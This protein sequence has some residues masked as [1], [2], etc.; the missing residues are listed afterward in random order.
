[1]AIMKCVKKVLKYLPDEHYIRLQYLCRLRKPLRL[2]NPQTFNEKLQWLKL[3]DR[4]PLYTRMVDK[5]EAKR[6]VTQ[7]IGEGYTAV[8]YGVWNRPEEIDFSALPS[9]FV[10]KTTHD[11]GGAYICRD[12]SRLIQGEALTPDGEA[13]LRMLD[14]HLQEDY[15]F[16]SREWPYHN[17][18]RR[19][20]AEEYLENPGQG[21]LLVYKVFCFG[22][23]PE[24][25]QVIQDDKTDRETIDYFDCEWNL[26]E[27]RQDFPNSAS[28]LPKPERL[29]EMLSLSSKLA[30]TRPFIRIDW[31]MVD[32]R[33]LFSEFTL[34]SDAG[35]A[36]FT[37]EIWD[38]KLGEKIQ[39]PA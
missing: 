2:R 15:Y 28:H 20:L 12:K 6:I 16:Q 3:Y 14:I 29:E 10:L 8:N 27:L 37:P 19:I 26:L 39:L 22:G 9:R 36:P 23:I 18:P 34:Y 11:C 30:G 4:D 35:M 38:E 5:Y 7:A 13:V 31:Y 33:L 25:I 17:V 21:S 32:G 24:L 1:M